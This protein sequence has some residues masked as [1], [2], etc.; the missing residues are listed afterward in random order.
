MAPRAQRTS[1]SEPEVFTYRWVGDHPGI[2]DGHTTPEGSA[3]AVEPGVEFSTRAPIDVISCPFAE[4]LSPN[5]QAHAQ[6]LIAAVEADTP[7]DADETEAP[8]G[9][10][11]PSQDEATKGT[12]PVVTDP[13]KEQA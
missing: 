10:E 6:D 9:D 8:A 5:A 4:P 3:A 2:I 12:E 11:A 7:E 1:A 13:D